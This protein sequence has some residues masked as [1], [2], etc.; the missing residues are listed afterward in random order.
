MVRLEM[1][2]PINY[3]STLMFEASVTSHAPVCNDPT[4]IAAI[5][6]GI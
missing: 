6:K 3:P 4:M 5:A 1:P 2:R